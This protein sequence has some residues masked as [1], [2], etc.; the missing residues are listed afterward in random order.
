MATQLDL[1]IR[2]VNEAS[3]VLKEVGADSEEM[4]GKIDKADSSLSKAGNSA[5]GFGSAIGEA[6]KIAGGFII[7]Q[8]IM[9]APDFLMGAAKA[10]AEDEQATMRL[11][12]ALRNSGGAFDENLAK[13]NE[14][15]SAGQ[16]LAYGDDDIRDSFQM[17]LAAT[18]DTDEALRRQAAA[19]D[20]ARGAGIPLASATKML[21][22]LNAENVEVFK[23]MGIVL[24][25]NATET[26]ALAAVQAKFG[27]QAEAYAKSTAGQWEILK[28]KM[29]ELVETIGVG[30]LPI[31]LK[32]GTVFAEHVMPKL[33]EFGAWIGPKFAAI[34]DWVELN[35]SPKILRAWNVFKIQVMPMLELFVLNA[36][37]LFET[38]ILPALDKIQ[39]FL[40]EKVVPALKRLADWFLNNKDAIE[41]A[42]VGLSAVL[43]VAFTAWAVS[44]G[45]AAV[46]T[47]AAAAPLIAIGLVVAGVAAGVFLLI[48]H[49]D[50][51]E[52]KYPALQKATDVLQEKFAKFK[53][54]MANEFLPLVATVFD[55]VK[56]AI[57]VVVDFVRDHWPEIESIVR[58]V[59]EQIANVVATSFKVITD[60]INIVVQLLNGDWKG[61]WRGAKELVSDVWNGITNTFNNGVQ[62]LRAL[63]GVFWDVAKALGGAIKDGFIDGIKG[64]LGIANTI[65]NAVIAL[66]E[67]AI[68]SMI[69]LVNNAIPDKISLPGLPDIDLPDNPIPLA[70]LPRLA[71]GGIVTEPTVAL[72]GEAG[73]EAIVPLSGPNARQVGGITVQIN[74]PIYGVDDFIYTLDRALKRAGQPGLVTA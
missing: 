74:A 47:I 72:I 3:K 13:V 32:I 38:K 10:A 16:K 2:M 42:A 51:L 71:K 18:G 29:G 27:G 26:D 50:D 53:D 73:P 22:K 21:G 57:S 14:R 66:F 68:N 54:W 62:F 43:V 55:R 5:K 46:A 61:A 48:K 30:L 19:M 39:S 12:Q 7:A 37:T 4:A 40:N 59:V 15:I 24:G 11:E 25:E 44:A 36:Q 60:V 23:K 20:L 56:T 65:A 69:G 6:A 67:N 31:M 45:A 35:V 33:E 8:G 41:A 49:W 52:K 70:S 17:L 1:A 63:G 64:A 34:A 58:P 9:K 28:I